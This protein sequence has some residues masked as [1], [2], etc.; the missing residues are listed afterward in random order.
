MCYCIAVCQEIC[1]IL[2]MDFCCLNTFS[3]DYMSGR[4]AGRWY[5]CP[6]PSMLPLLV[7]GSSTCAVVGHIFENNSHV[8]LFRVFFFSQHSVF[9]KGCGQLRVLLGSLVVTLQQQRAAVAELIS[10][11]ARPLQSILLTSALLS[12]TIF[13]LF[14]Q[15]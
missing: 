6:T 1:H 5:L 2:I 10:S 13:T 4:I 11:L 3:W 9:L 12:L 15:N 8:S 14:M 7:Q